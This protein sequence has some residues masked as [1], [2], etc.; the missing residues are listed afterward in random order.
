MRLF[1]LS[2]LVGA[3]AGCSK[4]DGLKSAALKVQV[5]YEGFRP[6][7]VTLT[8]TDQADVS[9]QVATNVNVPEGSPPGTLSVA[10]FRQAGWSNDVKLQAVAKEQSCDGAQVATAQTDASLAKDGI[11]PVDLS[12]AAVD[13]DGDGFVS[14]ANGGTDCDDRDE[15]R[16]GPIPWYPDDDSDGY[17]NRQLPAKITA[18][19]GPVFTASRSGDCDDRDPSV[20]PGQAEFRCD[21][22]DDNCDEVKDESFDV[23]GSC[24]NGFQCAGAKACTGTDGGVACNSTVTPT[25]YYRD[26]DGDRTAGADGGVTCAAQPEG[27]QPQV[28]DCDESSIHVSSTLTEVC[29][30]LDNNC[31][32]KV[33]EGPAPCDLTWRSVPEAAGVTSWRAIAVGKDL[34]WLAGPGTAGNVVKIETPARTVSTCAG[35]WNAAWVSSEGQ[36]FLAGRAG[37]L[38]S[39]M[40][41]EAGCTA[42]TT[43][44][45]PVDLSGIV[46][47]NSTTGG[48]PT[49]YAV[50]GG[51]RVFKWAFPA[52]PEQIAATSI[53]L[54][55]V[56]GTT[57]DAP[58]I[59]V[60]ARDYELPEPQPQ[61][62]SINPTDGTWVPETLPPAV[63][64][65]YLTG[66]SATNANYVYVVGYKGVVLERNH[67]VWRTLPPLASAPDVTDVLAFSQNGVYVTTATGTV[68]F[69]N[70]KTWDPFYSNPK[71]MRAID[72]YSP[73]Q[74]GA[75]G[76]QGVNQFFNR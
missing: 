5:H 10:V 4:G 28:T 64:N 41:D 37:K 47:F 57:A 30:R 55:A 76:D 66:V 20:H 11:T 58:L 13:G 19:S 60:G 32:E 63:P 53:N 59:A 50:S 9:R 69:F 25:A 54:M 44:G 33:D 15:D 43:P 8:V 17:G 72:G 29:D 74:L 38:A 3:L 52:A 35:D 31:N 6:G 70:G 46:G 49:L 24:L 62:I 67:G 75:S 12:L 22:R 36:L 42:A 18:C 51:G 1:L 14:P 48:K 68:Q 73:T 26:E 2:L 61:V 27:T 7:C 39:K 16:G 71:A 56:T 40:P 34:A 21:D 23:G 45:A 65:V